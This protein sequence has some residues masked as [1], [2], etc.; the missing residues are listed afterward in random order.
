MSACLNLSLRLI[1]HNNICTIFFFCSD[2][3][4]GHIRTKLLFFLSEYLCPTCKN[5]RCREFF[6]FLRGM[7]HCYV[8]QSN[9][10][11][12]SHS[13]LLPFTLSYMFSRMTIVDIYVLIKAACGYV[14]ILNTDRNFFYEMR[15]K[16]LVIFNRR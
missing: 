5:E 8:T 9:K 2:N 15:I 7:V 4:F 13:L 14:R 10:D 11:A 6:Y 3:M 12:S 16:Q 1:N